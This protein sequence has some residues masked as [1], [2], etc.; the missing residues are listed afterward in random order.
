[1][2]NAWQKYFGELE[3]EEEEEEDEDDD[4]EDDEDDDDEEDDEDEGDE[5]DE[6][7]E[8]DEEDDEEEDDEEDE[9]DDDDE[10]EERNSKNSDTT[11]SSNRSHSI[12]R[13]SRRSSGGHVQCPECDYRCERPSHL[14]IHMRTHTGERPYQCRFCTHSS[15]DKSN[16]KKH[17]KRKHKEMLQTLELMD[18]SSSSSVTF[19]GFQDVSLSMPFSIDNISSGVGSSSSNAQESLP[20]TATSTATDSSSL[21]VD[22]EE[23]IV[24]DDGFDQLMSVSSTN[25]IFK[26]RFDTDEDINTAA[27]I[28]PSESEHWTQPHKKARMGNL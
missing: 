26:R 13:R 10:E 19:E 11:S 3:E 8:D 12:S 7:D 20:S 9:E 16:L 5:E 1:M 21:S 15:A 22:P 28:T 4:E 18:G 2:L 14:E 24:F 6:E 25:G 27:S 17:E 23:E